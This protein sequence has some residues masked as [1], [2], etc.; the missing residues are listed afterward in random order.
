MLRDRW[1]A[2]A[3]AMGFGAI[4]D[5]AFAASILVAPDALSRLFHIP[6]PEDRFYVRLV[7]LL[8]LILGAIYLLPARDPHRFHAIAPLAATGRVCGFLLFALAW[9]EGRPPAFLALGLADLVI[10]TVTLAV[11]MRARA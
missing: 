9:R 3:L 6:L 10:A 4:Y 8:L 2:L 11:W 5:A 7:A 1:R